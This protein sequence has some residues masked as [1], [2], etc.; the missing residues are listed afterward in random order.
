MIHHQHHNAYHQQHNAQNA[1]HEHDE[2]L[3][4]GIT[5]P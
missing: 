2:M 5:T 3:M 4:M 1:Y